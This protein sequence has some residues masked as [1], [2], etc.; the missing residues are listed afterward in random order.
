MG[1]P[2]MTLTFIIVKYYFLK[3]IEVY[4]LIRKKPSTFQNY[5]TKLNIPLF[6]ILFSHGDQNEE[7]L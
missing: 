6:K 4:F 2:M 1:C 5:I 7:F 3:H